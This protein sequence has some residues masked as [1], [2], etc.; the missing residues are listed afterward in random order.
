MYLMDNSYNL[1]QFVIRRTTVYS[2]KSAINII[3][4]I[5][6]N[7]KKERIMLFTDQGIK[8]AG[9]L[10]RVLRVFEGLGDD[11]PKIVYIYDQV[12]AEAKISRIKECIKIAEENQIDCLLGIGGGSVLDTVKATKWLM[13]NKGKDIESIF[14]GSPTYVEKWPVAQNMD[15][16]HVAVPTTAGTGTES[17]TTAALLDEAT[18]RKVALL[19]PFLAADIALLDPEMTVTLP[20]SLTAGTGLDAFCHSFESFFSPAANPL[21]DANAKE[22]MHLV[23]KYLPTAVKDGSNLEARENMLLASALGIAAFGYT[24]MAR[25]SIHNIAIGFALKYDKPHCVGIPTL[26]PAVVECIPEWYAYRCKE[27]AQVVGIEKSFQTD[28]EAYKAV[29]T[30]LKEFIASVG[31]SAKF[32]DVK[33]SDVDLEDIV[34]IVDKKVASF[35]KIP[36]E[37]IRMVAKMVTQ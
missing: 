30:W 20:R 7:F 19:N 16:P 32:A 24:G 35:S 9:V 29:L 17:S 33:L 25:A 18:N 36:A 14:S 5:F 31:V 3:P 6:K 4:Q 21:S 37:K 10:D 28:E 22:G 23:A 2:G 8:N 12:E 11:M 13:Y 34:Q 26:L 1:F 27:F 15:I